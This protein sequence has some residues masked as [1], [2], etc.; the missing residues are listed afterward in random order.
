MFAAVVF[1][2]YLVDVVGLRLQTFLAL[3]RETS[4]AET[5]NKIPSCPFLFT[6]CSKRVFI[7]FFV[8]TVSLN[9]GT[10]DTKDKSY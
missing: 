4:V 5:K 2:G 8:C 3:P 7:R 10:M 6:G 1:R 9:K